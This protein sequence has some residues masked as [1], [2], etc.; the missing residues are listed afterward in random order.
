MPSLADLRIVKLKHVDPNTSIEEG[1]LFVP[2]AVGE[3]FEAELV[4]I[5]VRLSDDIGIFLKSRFVVLEEPTKAS[6]EI[7]KIRVGL[8]L[9]FF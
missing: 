5:V 4:A 1:E 3:L 7:V 2:A 6:I 8:F 9:V